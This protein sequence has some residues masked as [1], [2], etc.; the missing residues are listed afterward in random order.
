MLEGERVSERLADEHGLADPM[1]TVDSD[2][3]RPLLASDAVEKYLLPVPSHK[4]RPATATC[5]NGQFKSPYAQFKTM[6]RGRD[7][8]FSH[9]AALEH[10]L[11]S[12]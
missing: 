8:A 9:A 11:A 5:T 12:I 10:M 2:E 3:L 7:S 6:E 1:A 4:Q